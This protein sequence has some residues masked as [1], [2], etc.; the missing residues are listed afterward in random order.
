MLEAGAKFPWPVSVV[1]AEQGG[2]PKC[3]SNVLREDSASSYLFLSLSLPLPVYQ[4]LPA[5]WLACP[6]GV[7]NGAALA[8]EM[9]ILAR[10]FSE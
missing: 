1:N 2:P 4:P 7:T 3:C 8:M 10:C 6:E 9:L 5:Q